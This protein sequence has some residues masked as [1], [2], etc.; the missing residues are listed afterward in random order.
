MVIISFRW[1]CECCLAE[2]ILSFIRMS[3]LILYHTNETYAKQTQRQPFE[4]R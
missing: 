1:L 4:A 3:V 2:K